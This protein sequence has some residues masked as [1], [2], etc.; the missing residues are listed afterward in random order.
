M[1][2]WDAFEARW[3]DALLALEAKPVDAVDNLLLAGGYRGNRE[4]DKAR[5]L[6]QAAFE[7]D[8][9]LPGA[10][11]WL[12]YCTKRMGKYEDALK[13]FEQA[14]AADPTNAVVPYQMARIVLGIDKKDDP[15]DPA[16]AL[17]LAEAAAK[18]AGGASPAY[19][20]LVARCQAKGGDTGAALKTVKAILKHVE[21]DADKAYYEALAAEL[22]GK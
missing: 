12:A 4:W 5:E 15:G 14:R 21:E 3:K 16:K 1:D 13:L 22:K 11:Y 19:L 6:Y 20:E 9:K 17:V 2:D 18:L 7:A 8:P 10:L